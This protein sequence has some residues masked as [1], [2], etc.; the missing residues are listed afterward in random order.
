MT[1]VTGEINSL[2]INIEARAF[3]TFNQLSFGMV[4]SKLYLA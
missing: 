3:V 2:T 1:L 4:K